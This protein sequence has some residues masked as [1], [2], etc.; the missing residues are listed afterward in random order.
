MGGITRDLATFLSKTTFNDIPEN[1][2]HEAKRRILDYCG[3]T[4]AGSTRPEGKMISEFVRD[5]GGKEEAT[6]IGSNFKASCVDAALANGTM[7]HVV[8][9]GDWGRKSNTHGGETMGSATFAL[10]ERNGIDGKSLITAWVMGSEAAQRVGNASHPALR[11]R[12]FHA[13]GCVATFGAAAACAKILNLDAD[14]Y[15]QA[16]GHAGTQSAGLLA[17]LDEGAMSKRLH[18]GK[19]NQAG[20]IAALLAEK[21]FTGPRAILE[22]EK[23][24]LRAFTQWPEFKYYP[25]KVTEDLGKEWWIMNINIKIHACCGYFPPGIDIFQDFVQDEGLKIEDIEQIRLASYKLSIDGHKDA[26]P[27]TIVG[28]TMS[29][30]YCIAVVL[31]TG[32]CSLND[33]TVEKL[34]DKDFMNLVAEIGAKSEFIIDPEMD[35]VI[36]EKYPATVEV[37]LTNGK[38]LKKHVDLPRGFYPE[39]PVI[40]TQLDEKFFDLATMVIS[41]DKAQ[42]LRDLVMD[43]ENLKDMR[44]LTPL[45]QP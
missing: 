4:L 32:K 14:K 15:E 24:F 17:F 35:K 11:S 37:K 16:I 29:Y 31:S 19:G 6:L 39:N 34:N 43:L 21:G 30:P 5:L 42:K 12:G 40:E 38:V 44:E 3:V 7:S 23:G 36:P 13:N 22:T 26:Q 27:T 9:L 45:L 2:R 28:A 1:V 25:E 33:F 18:T 41:K 8:E 20:V 10:G